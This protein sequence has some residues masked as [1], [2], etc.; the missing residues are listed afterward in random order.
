[1]NTLT[2]TELTTANPPTGKAAN[3]WL[4]LAIS[5]VYLLTRLWN[6]GLMPDFF[7]EL[8]STVISTSSTP[9]SI[10]F[11][12]H[13]PLRPALQFLASFVIQPPLIAG[14]TVSVIAGLVGLLLLYALGR[15]LWNAQA[16]LAAAIL[17]LLS[18]YVLVHTRMVLTEPLQ[19]TAMLA[20]LYLAILLAAYQKATIP[21]WLTLGLGLTIGLA[22]LTKITSITIFV[23]VLVAMVLG[24]AVK[25]AEKAGK[26]ALNF[27]G[28]KWLAFA[29]ACLI[30]LVLFSMQLVGKA[31]QIYLLGDK[32]NSDK[33]RFSFKLQDI[34]FSPG[35]T[36]GPRLSS[37][38]LPTLIDFLTLPVAL[39]LAAAI[40]LVPL[41]L[42]A[43][44]SPASRRAALQ[45]C[46]P[47]IASL[48][49]LALPIFYITYTFN[50]YFATG[51]V[52]LFLLGGWFLD[53]LA[54]WLRS[55]LLPTTSTKPFAKL[56][57]TSGLAILVSILALPFSVSFL[58]D[59][60]HAPLPAAAKAEYIDGPASGY[61]LKELSAAVRHATTTTN[62]PVKLMLI[63]P[64]NYEQDLGWGYPL[65]NYMRVY[66]DNG[67]YIPTNLALF[68]DLSKNVFQL[69]ALPTFGIKPD[70][71][72]LAA[73]EG[74]SAK[75][76]DWLKLNPGFQ[77]IAHYVGPGS[78]S[79]TLYQYTGSS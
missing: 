25:L 59:P 38:V 40:V 19:I 15:K 61:G 66:P 34:L 39:I 1:M 2:K 27:S 48:T 37:Y 36:W 46:I 56:L 58:T 21:I 67:V 64:S 23:W 63:S 13:G 29:I 79:F 41:N 60:V 11:M 35:T 7:D 3:F 69:P 78:R 8:D 62:Q 55:K 43:S 54:N 9:V 47:L 12:G 33:T 52:P 76:L 18:P 70:S 31:G 16:G 42:W 4:L 57:F 5:V 73:V 75:Q 17:Y 22:T 44:R 53:Y 71:Q 24:G 50:R 20:A 51:L 49:A 28:R 72:T 32:A 10:A 26:P 6:L 68:E 45:A 77:P 74:T 30:G 65:L 14:R